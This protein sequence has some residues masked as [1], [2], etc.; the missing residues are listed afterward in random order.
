MGGAPALVASI[1]NEVRG[2][3]FQGVFQPL[4]N[5]AF[6]VVASSKQALSFPSAA[7]PAADLAVLAASGSTYRHPSGALRLRACEHA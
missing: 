4:C 2:D 3:D 5:C 6:F 1:E 7:R